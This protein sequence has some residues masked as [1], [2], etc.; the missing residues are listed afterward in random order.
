MNL[1]TK[2][3]RAAS[4]R[5]GRRSPHLSAMANPHPSPK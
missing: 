3:S 1:G 2:F 5:Y 4:G